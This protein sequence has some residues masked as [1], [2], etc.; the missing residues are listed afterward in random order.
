MFNVYEF[1][2]QQQEKA[3]GQREKQVRVRRTSHLKSKYRPSP[4]P[5]QP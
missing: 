5:G 4:T 1:D 2:K 3:N